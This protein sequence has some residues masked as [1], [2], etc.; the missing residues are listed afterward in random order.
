MEKSSF[1]AYISGEVQGVGFRYYT[2]RNATS[3]NITGYV[4]NLPD[5]RVEVVGEGEKSILQKFADTLREGPSASVVR[6][7]D[8]TW[9][10][11]EQKY[12]RFFIETGGRY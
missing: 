9:K 8:I 12:D 1:L 4:K 3:M 6:D 5:G 10:E 11:F 2:Y 7:F